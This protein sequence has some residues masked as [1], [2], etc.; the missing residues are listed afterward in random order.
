MGSRCWISPTPAARCCTPTPSP[1]DYTRMLAPDLD[2]RFFVVDDQ[3]STLPGWQEGALMSAEH[4]FRQIT[5][6]ED[7]WQSFEDIRED[8][9]NAPMTLDVMG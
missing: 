9:E 7:R 3:V 2:G 4:V 8:V 1:A 5:L 6:G